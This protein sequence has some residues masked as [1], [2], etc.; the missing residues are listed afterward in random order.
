[1]SWWVIWKVLCVDVG[2]LRVVCW[3]WCG[4][5]CGGLCADGIG[6]CGV[7]RVVCRGRCAKGG[8]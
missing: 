1:M 4:D 8:V 7:L 3:W 6:E 2:V 5:R